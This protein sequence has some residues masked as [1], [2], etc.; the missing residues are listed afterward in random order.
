[1]KLVI[2]V[3]TTDHLK[4]VKKWVTQAFSIIP[5]RELP[6]Q[7]YANM[8]RNGQISNEAGKMPYEGNAHE[9]MVLQSFADAN[10]LF[11]VWCIPVD[12][13]RFEKKSLELIESLFSHK[14]DGSLF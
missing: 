11:F 10:T 7:H 1:M 9:M 4:Q 5:M 6:P 12:F 2:Q 3:H 14:G 8:D 13:K